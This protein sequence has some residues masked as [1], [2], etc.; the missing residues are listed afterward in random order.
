MRIK[1]TQGIFHH[2]VRDTR[3]MHL[4]C[5]SFS[6]RFH[7][8]KCIIPFIFI[9]ITIAF[10]IIASSNSWY[11]THWGGDTGEETYDVPDEV[12]PE[13]EKPFNYCCGNTIFIGGVVF[14]FIGVKLHEKKD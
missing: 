13:T 2:T 5:D 14:T 7:F 10:L 4:G 11:D 3:K 1:K 9:L 6:P 8:S 12:E